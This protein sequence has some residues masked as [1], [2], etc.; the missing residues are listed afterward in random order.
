MKS[1]RFRTRID[2]APEVRDRMVGSLNQQLADT[3][4]LYSQTK[5]AHWNVKGA[6]F[7]PLH[8]L[9][10]EL[11]KELAE[12][13]DSLAER[14]TALGATPMGTVRM[15]AGA[16]RLPEWSDDATADLHCVEMLAARFAAVAATTRAAIDLAASGGDAV[17][18]DLFT[19]IARGLD[20][21][22]WF[23]E[24]HLQADSV[25]ALPERDV[26]LA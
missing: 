3:F 1:P 23:L 6:E 11:A 18:A 15:S 14:V 25:A 19:E 26:M 10:D 12:H 24:A 16:S 17:T 13:A 9:F 5:Q 21:R 2:L 4:D 22:L 20:K 7:Y 8:Q